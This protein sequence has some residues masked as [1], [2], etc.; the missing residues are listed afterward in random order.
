VILRNPEAR[1]PADRVLV[2][3]PEYHRYYEKGA[4]TSPGPRNKLLYRT[5]TPWLQLCNRSTQQNRRPFTGRAT[6][7]LHT[8]KNSF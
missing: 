5:T 2:G 8:Q 6:A 4:K 7:P 3:G 1:E